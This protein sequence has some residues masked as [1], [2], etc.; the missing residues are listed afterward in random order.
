MNNIPKISVVI[1]CY[2]R[3]Q[4]TQRLCADLLEQ[5]LNGWEAFFIGDNCPEFEK[6]IDE[7]YF[8]IQQKIAR[9]NNNILIFS[10]LPNHYGGYGYEIRNRVK[11]LA[12]GKYIC[13]VD[14]DDRIAKNHLEN[15]YFGINNTDLDFAY[16]D[17]YIHP[18]SKTRVTELENGKIG[19]SELVIL[20]DLYKR[21]PLQNP[22]YGHDWKLVS[23]ML[24]AGAKHQK[25][26]APPTYMVMGLGELREKGID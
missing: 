6:I 19:H 23:D 9:A 25:I 24:N 2:G 22:E 3:P 17:S 21:M 11:S 18:T 5:S 1:P 4:R 14:N 7:G 8:E 15:Y 12:H 10:N 26:A 20:T 13:F 16:F